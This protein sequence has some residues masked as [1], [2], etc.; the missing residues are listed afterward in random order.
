MKHMLGS[1]SGVIRGFDDEFECYADSG[2]MQVMVRTG[3]CWIQSHWGASS[4]EKT[5]PID[6]AD[7]TDPRKDRVVL[8]ADFGNNRIELEVLTGTPAASPTTPAVT[9]NT[10]QWETSVAIVDVAA[11]ATTIAAEDATDDRVYTSSHARYYQSAVQTIPTSTHTGLV[12]DTIDYR[13]GGVE[14]NTDW[15]VF[16]FNRTGLW[17]V[18]TN[19]RWASNTTGTRAL[20]LAKTGEL[21]ARI[22]ESVVSADAFKAALNVTALFRIDTAGE[23]VTS[24][25]WQDSGGALDTD[26][27]AGTTSISFVW[28]SP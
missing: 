2:G 7:P 24:Y 21:T 27:G 15:D 19:C 10:L 5:L 28:V 3:Q 8:R 9:Q 25:A 20:I 6:A 4:S 17:T 13:A 12:F 18:V 11:G 16:T 26:V 1:Q 23:Q 14:P 22:G